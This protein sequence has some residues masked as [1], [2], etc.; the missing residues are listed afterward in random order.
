VIEATRSAEDWGQLAAAHN[1]RGELLRAERRWAEAAAA[2]RTS[3]RI[4]DEALEH[5]PLLYALWNLPQ[6]LV[7]LD[8]AAPAALLMGHAAAAWTAAFGPLAADDLRDVR[9]VR[10][11]A[12]RQIGSA[13][14]SRALQE[15]GRMP[16][17]AV[18]RLALGAALP[19]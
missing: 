10:R 14:V 12:A 13:R 19:P 2:Y 5:M 9:R 15:G 7:H 16:L 18:L 6:A 1:Q 11:L 3:L 17:A 4:A 8:G